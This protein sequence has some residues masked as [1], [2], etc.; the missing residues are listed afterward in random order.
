[1]KKF[2]STSSVY[3]LLKSERTKKQIEELKEEIKEKSEAM[4][5]VHSCRLVAQLPVSHSTISCVIQ[6]VSYLYKI[7]GC[8]I[9]N[10]SIMGNV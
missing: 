5:T 4:N 2:E 3:D 6:K 10:H 9:L 1:M 7:Q 8:R